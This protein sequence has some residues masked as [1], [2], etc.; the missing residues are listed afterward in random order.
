MKHIVQI[1]AQIQWQVKQDP[2][3]RYFIAVCDPLGLTVEGETYGELVD[4]L[5]DGLSLLMR[6]WVRHGN[7]DA[8]LRERGWSVVPDPASPADL[9]DAY[10]DVPFELV[11]KSARDQANHVH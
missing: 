8:F 4:N 11:A 10:F 6:S 2:A 5:K 7:F 3:S 1:A 9:E